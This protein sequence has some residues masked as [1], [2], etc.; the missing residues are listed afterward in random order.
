MVIPAVVVDMGLDVDVVVEVVVVEVVVVSGVVD[1]GIAL[2]VTLRLVCETLILGSVS[3][4]SLTITS[5][6]F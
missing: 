2:V 5:F 4:D 6:S 1:T 3:D